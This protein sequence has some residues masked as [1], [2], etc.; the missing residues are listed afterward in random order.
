MNFHVRPAGEGSLLRTETRV[1]AN[2]ARAR[3]RFA[4]YWRL[5]YPG[6]SLIRYAWLRAIAKRVVR[7]S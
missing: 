6:S 7:S 2:G 3:R 1:F 5:I 4:W